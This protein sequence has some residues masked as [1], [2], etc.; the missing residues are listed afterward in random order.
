M[1]GNTSFT[2]SSPE[3]VNRHIQHKEL[4]VYAICFKIL[5]HTCQHSHFS[6]GYKFQCTGCPQMQ[7]I[8]I[9]VKSYCKTPT[10]SCDSYSFELTNL[11]HLFYVLCDPLTRQCWRHFVSRYIFV[12]VWPSEDPLQILWDT[13]H[14]VQHSVN[15]WHKLNY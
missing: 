11:T 12:Y 6:S 1:D 15:E 10:D 8:F 5:L 4:Y 14:T 13:L 9:P 2:I 7:W 3:C